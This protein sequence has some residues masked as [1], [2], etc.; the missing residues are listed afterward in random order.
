MRGAPRCRQTHARGEG[1]LRPPPGAPRTQATSQDV[2]GGG[3]HGIPPH[4]PEDAASPR[5]PGRAWGRVPCRRTQASA[6]P[7]PPWPA[8]PTS[9]VLRPSVPARRSTGHAAAQGTMGLVVPA[10]RKKTLQGRPLQLQIP[11]ALP[12]SDVTRHAWRRP[13]FPQTE[14]W[15]SVWVSVAFG[16]LA[17]PWFFVFSA[18]RA[19]PGRMPA[20]LA[21]FAFLLPPPSRPCLVGFIVPV[22]GS[23]VNGACLETVGAV[24]PPDHAN[25]GRRSSGASDRAEGPMGRVWW[26]ET[27][28]VCSVRSSAVGT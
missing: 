13:A 11:G 2:G 15:M 23:S 14:S 5:R 3:L 17:C 27:K 18:P 4:R 6:R 26:W 20:R 24:A 9:N 1:A 19:Q 7:P 25:P 21:G 12:G 10:R 22:A 16:V 8:A 28:M